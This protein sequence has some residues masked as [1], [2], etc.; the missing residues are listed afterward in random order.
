MDHD[1]ITTQARRLASRL[2]PVVGQVFFSPECHAAYVDLGFG[3]SP[4]DFAGVAAPDGP[5]YFT[6]RGSLLGQVQP[7]VVA[8]AFGVFNPAIVV[9]G[10]TFGWSITDAA[11][12]FGAR[13]RGAVAQLERILGAPD[14]S[15]GRAGELLVRAVTPLREEGRPLFAGLRSWW[16]D[17][18]GWTKV[19][20]LGDM[21]R[22][23][24]GDAH[25]AAWTSAG[26]DAV[27]IGLLT[28]CYIG[29]PM[30]TYIRTRAWDDAALDA[31][32]ER[33]EARRWL[34]DNTLTELG[35]TEREQ[36]ERTTD[37]AL[38]LALAALGDDVVELCDLLEPWGKLVRDAGGYIGGPVD[39]WPA[40][41]RSPR[42]K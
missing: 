38:T 5:A 31:A 22:E 6:S 37:R 3:P 30:R 19:F 20:H 17:P 26:L 42:G 32:T 24:R 11:T 36:I 16:D 41:R 14:S 4:G 40:D 25:I 10:V 1:T 15:T 39:L 12:I 13:R 9:P 21:L 34:A 28:E 33:L 27:E 2:E 23:Y 29:L 7:H 8:S 18:D 35:R